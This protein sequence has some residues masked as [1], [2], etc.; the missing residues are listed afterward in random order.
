MSKLSS[1]MINKSIQLFC[2]IT[3]ILSL[4]NSCDILLTID[5]YIDINTVLLLPIGNEDNIGAEAYFDTQNRRAD[6]ASYAP[7]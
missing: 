3:S 6:V 4:N 7:P 5:K 2:L 1:S